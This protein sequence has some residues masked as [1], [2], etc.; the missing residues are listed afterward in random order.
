MKRIIWEVFDLRMVN[1]A[2]NVFTSLLLLG[3]TAIFASLAWWAM[4]YGG[5]EGNLL[6][7]FNSLHEGWIEVV[8]LTLLLPLLGWRV[9]YLLRSKK[10]FE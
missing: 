4:R 2:L 7:T 1:K 10:V 8:V 5:P 3:F 6:I 9:W